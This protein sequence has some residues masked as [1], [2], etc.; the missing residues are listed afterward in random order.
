[1]SRVT[2]RVV[3]VIVLTWLLAIFGCGQ[4]QH[5]DSISISPNNVTINGAGLDLHYTALGH[6]SH[7]LIP[8]T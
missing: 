7:P 2:A 1:M 3:L 5:L 6:Y 8:R 4:D